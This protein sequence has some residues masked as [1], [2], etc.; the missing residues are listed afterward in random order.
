[1]L[2]GIALA[3]PTA[4]RTRIS[5]TDH[6]RIPQ[7]SAINY[8]D[9]AASRQEEPLT[10]LAR[11]DKSDHPAARSSHHHRLERTYQRGRRHLG[12]TQYCRGSAHLR[13]QKDPVEPRERQLR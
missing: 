8:F 12:L 2:A 4:A 7:R 6:L 13:A 3:V 11:D 1:M 9:E 10:N 5:V